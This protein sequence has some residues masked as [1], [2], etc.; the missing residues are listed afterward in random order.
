MTP[1][2]RQLSHCI[3]IGFLAALVTS[4]AAF[5]QDSREPSPR[6]SANRILSPRSF[7][8]GQ[9]FAMTDLPGGHLRRGLEDLP[10]P[11]RQRAMGWLRSFHFS[12]MDVPYMRVDDGGAVFYEDPERNGAAGQG[13]QHGEFTP[14]QA[15][16]VEAQLQAITQQTA[17]TLHSKLGA[18]K[19]VH[20]DMDGHVVSGTRWNYGREDPLYMRPYDTDG[21]ESS[22]ST[23]ELQVIAE[24]WK[25]IAEDYAPFDIDVTTEPPASYGPN[26]GHILV[27]RKSDENGNVIY[28][29][30]CGG[31]AYVG[32][33]GSSNFTY[34]QPALV[35]LD[36]VGGAHNIS[37]AASHEL[38]HNL[39]LSHDAT[40]SVGYY[41]GHGSGWTDWAPIMGAG[42]SAQVTQWSKGE[43][44]DA[45]NQQD[46][47]AIIA[48]R[49][50]YRVDDHANS[51]FNLATPLDV[52][53]DTDVVATNPVNDPANSDTANKGVIEDR[54][55]VDLFAMEVGAGNIDLTITPAWVSNF[56]SGSRRGTNLDIRAR[57]FA[58][59]G[60]LLDTDDPGDNTF[61]RITVNGLPAGRYILAID[62]VGAGNPLN[63]GYSDYG[64]IGQYFINGTV[65]EGSPK[66]LTA[67]GIF[68]PDSIDEDSSGSF[69]ATATWDDGSH[70][71]VAASWSEDSA[72]SSISSA[73]LLT[74]TT[75]T[76]DTQVTIQASYSVGGVTKNANKL[77]TI[78]D[79]GK[80]L[81][82]LTISGPSSVNEDSSASYSATAQWDDGTSSSA[83]ASWSENASFTTI[84]SNGLLTA[85][86]LIGDQNVTVSASY[87]SNGVVK[88][89]NK[90]VTVLDTVK[91][92]SSLQIAGADSLEE[93][94]S[95]SYSATAQ[96]DDGSSSSVAATWEEDS[97]YATIDSAGLLQADRVTASEGLKVTARFTSDGVTKSATKAVTILDVRKALTGLAISGPARLHERGK[98]AFQAM[99]RWD[100]GSESEVA[101]KWSTSSDFA[102]VSKTG[103]LSA[104][105]VVGNQQLTLR[106]RYTSNGDTESVA[107]EIV[108]TDRAQSDFDGDGDSDIFWRHADKGWNRLWFMADGQRQASKWTPRKINV[109]QVAGLGDFN[110]DGLSDVLWR[111]P[112]TGANRL[113]S[114]DGAIRL[115]DEFLPYFGTSNWQVVDLGDFDGDGMADILW[116]NVASRANR[117]WLMD[118]AS[119]R[120]TVKLPIYVNRHWQPVG[121]GD[122]NGDGQAD[123]VWRHDVSG[124]NRVW[125]MDDGARKRVL[126]LP[127]FPGSLWKVVGLGDFDGDARSDIVWRNGANGANRV[128]LMSAAKIKAVGFLP[129]LVDQAWTLAG[130]GDYDGSGGA[131]LLWR[132]LTT[133]ASKV[134]LMGG[135][136][137]SGQ[138]F[139]PQQGGSAWQVQ[140]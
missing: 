118:G 19:V 136:S 87:S 23:S 59:D 79:V 24:V 17:F 110:A 16:A 113:W 101:A 9:T 67:L 121:V 138:I 102:W 69:S 47:L 61:A 105:R 111:N 29:C 55:D 2:R 108:V 94:A 1:F 125:I 11:A 74:A 137:R 48:G 103:I 64:S 80:L 70:S 78:T 100:D 21:D 96:W 51:D 72:Y 128:W 8:L 20:L 89:A 140:H 14:E 45:N 133:G 130:T 44:Q 18:S 126:V 83:N 43:Y 7:G 50:G 107:R 5:A 86:N 68:G 66:V 28:T 77:V 3:A 92:L 81:V 71:S 31:V 25:R 42:Y 39:G 41:R 120:E 54:N 98:A 33:W 75:V 124:A 38:G 6:E 139:L 122:F 32:V 91:L 22:F 84:D 27:T 53:D 36:G 30:T 57:L 62:G 129:K 56:A 76:A 35:F 97:A 115:S 46:D 132:N 131:D 119:R 95:T 85:S 73:G 52:I 106:A 65:P 13:H 63:T 88:V 134:W 60:T 109:W 90:S 123:I 99:A 104:K 34:Y 4:T 10:A 116:H 49:L 15:D 135:A 82:D 93:E 37:E 58:A 40:S 112:A 26:V 12:E 127:S 117:L 114:M